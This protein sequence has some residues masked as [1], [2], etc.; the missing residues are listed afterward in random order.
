M[1]KIF[2]V[3]FIF[4]FFCGSVCSLEHKLRNFDFTK[5]SPFRVKEGEYRYDLRALIRYSMRNSYDTRQEMEVLFQ[6]RKAA[7]LKLS[8][9]LPHANL[10]Q[11]YS[12]DITDILGMA[13]MFVGFLFPNR[14][15]DWKQQRV[16]AKS[17]L[18]SFKTMLAN[19]ANTVQNVYYSI[20]VQMWNLLI[21]KHY[22]DEVERLIETLEEQKNYIIVRLVKKRLEY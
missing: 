3:F 22:I 12:F 14:W 15:F 18:E 5:D 7:L 6:V 13:T 8:S 2:H 4:A 21:V 19:R 9:M 11:A 20:Q 10:A 17:E 16:L 1:A